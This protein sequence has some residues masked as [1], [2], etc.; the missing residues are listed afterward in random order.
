[1]DE[2]NETPN[3]ENDAG[4]GDSPG[5]ATSTGAFQPDKIVGEAGAPF[6][7]DRVVLRGLLSK[8][9]T[10]ADGA[11]FYRLYASTLLD[12]WLEIRQDDLKGQFQSE[13]GSY[14]WVKRD[15]RLVEM[16]QARACQFAETGSAFDVDPT[17]SPAGR[18]PRYGGGP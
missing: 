14:V 1:M 6:T 5:D 13:G 2:E 8:Q 9:E 7:E 16:H 17:S 4:N 15:A 10:G 18:T 3:G 12:R 11:A